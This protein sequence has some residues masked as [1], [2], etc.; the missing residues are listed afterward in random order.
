MLK[1]WCIAEKQFI[2]M[3][4]IQILVKFRYPVV[5]SIRLNFTR[6]LPDTSVFEIGETGV[7]TLERELK[8]CLTGLTS[9]AFICRLQDLFQFYLNQWKHIYV[10]FKFQL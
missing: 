3:H 10:L 7:K 8:S 1:G 4:R 9:R 2:G 5:F 6:Y